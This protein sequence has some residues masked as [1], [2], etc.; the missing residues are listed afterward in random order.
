MTILWLHR[1]TPDVRWCVVRA[2]TPGMRISTLCL[3]DLP[4]EAVCISTVRP[5]R[6]CPA[7]ETELR[8]GT[9]GAAVAIEPAVPRVVTRDLRVRRV[10]MDDFG[11]EWSRP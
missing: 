1:S 9:P 11:E 5:H 2:A 10:E 8:A 3:A 6:T 7:C 4:Y